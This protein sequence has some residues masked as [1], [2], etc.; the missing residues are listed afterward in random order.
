[1]ERRTT[2]LSVVDDG[3]S[4]SRVYERRNAHRS[5]YDADITTQGGARGCSGGDAKKRCPAAEIGYRELRGA[6]GARHRV[7]VRCSVPAPVV[8][9]C[10][11]S[12]SCQHR[13]AARWLGRRYGK[14][15]VSV[16]SAF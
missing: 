2:R 4:H 3:D 11:G 9:T 16:P 5:L 1:M 14:I 10:T 8:P 13:P 12:S 6:A 7:T 15:I